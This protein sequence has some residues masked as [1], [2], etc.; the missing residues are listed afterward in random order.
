M[1]VSQTEEWTSRGPRVDQ[2]VVKVPE[3]YVLDSGDQFSDGDGTV[4][5]VFSINSK[6][7]EINFFW[8]EINHH[9]QKSDNLWHVDNELA[10]WTM[11]HSA[12]LKPLKQIEAIIS[13]S[14]GRPIC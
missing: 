7:H 4:L 1:V 6:T 2:E 10:F 8:T 12:G 5:E 3:G 11:I 13:M 9:L 14:I